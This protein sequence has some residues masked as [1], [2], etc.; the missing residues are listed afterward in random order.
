MD[1]IIKQIISILFQVSN[2]LLGSYLHNCQM[3]CIVNML[4]VGGCVKI[5][6]CSLYIL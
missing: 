2:F 1:L 5:V 4:Q 3:A 6:F